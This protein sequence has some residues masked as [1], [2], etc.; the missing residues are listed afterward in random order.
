MDLA[1]AVLVLLS[2]LSHQPNELL[3]HVGRY[4]EMWGDVG[5]YGLSQ[6]AARHAKSFTG[7]LGVRRGEPRLH[8][9][10]GG[11]CTRV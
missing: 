11:D 7:P 6:G 9:R 5:R 8:P 4:G 1:H 3:Q 2:E 10:L